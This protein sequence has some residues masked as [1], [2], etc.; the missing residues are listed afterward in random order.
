MV[1]NNNTDN[2]NITNVHNEMIY[3]FKLLT[4]WDCADI[5]NGID[6]SWRKPTVYKNDYEPHIREGQVK[7]ARPSQVPYGM[8][9]VNAIRHVGEL[10]K[11]DLGD[12]IDNDVEMQLSKYDVGAFYTMHTDDDISFKS[13]MEWPI[14]K[15]SASLQLSDRGDY[16]GGELKLKSNAVISHEIGS[17]VVFPSFIE[18]EV[19]PVTKGTR[20]SLVI[21]HTGPRWR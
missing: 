6:S 7:F 3:Q 16:E 13:K 11:I 10:M 12:N 20:Y 4:R 9:I 2:Y 1:P 19:V 18:H 8:K 17:L 21:W 15:L 5:I 14:R